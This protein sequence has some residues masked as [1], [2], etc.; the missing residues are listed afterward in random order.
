MVHGFWQRAGLDFTDLFAPVVKPGTIRTVLQ[1][2][3][4]RVWLVHQLD[5]SNAFLHGHLAEQVFCQQPTGFID[6]EHPDHVC[7]LSFSLRV[8]ADAMGMV[9]AY[10]SLPAVTWIPVHP[11]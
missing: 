7:A 1:L 4:S 3:V 11:L 5:V 9:P 6:A 8:D 2:A 10:L